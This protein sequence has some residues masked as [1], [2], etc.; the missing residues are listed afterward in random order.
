MLT[1]ILAAIA[2]GLSTSATAAPVI[3]DFTGSGRTCA[4]TESGLN[5]P[6]TC[7][8]DVSFTGFMRLDVDPAGPSGF[9]SES[10]PATK[11]DPDGWV[12]SFF[13]IRWAGG[14]FVT[15]P[16][17]HESRRE[18]WAY[19]GLIEH[20]DRNYDLMYVED[21]IRLGELR[22]A[23][24]DATGLYRTRRTVL[25]LATDINIRWVDVERF[26]FGITLSPPSSEPY[27]FGNRPM[28]G[29]EDFTTVNNEMQAGSG[30]G[31]I[32]LSSLVPRGAAAQVPEP[33]TWVLALLS[34]VAIAAGLRRRSSL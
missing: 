18:D 29:F 9:G 11:Y 14:T 28:I 24:D 33:Q 22:V 4:Y 5:P 3:Y 32:V 17:P 23:G 26:P 31:S 20:Y 12:D 8:E 19:V 2:L 21:V 30:F 7:N 6:I 15:T 13:N 34:A 1:R 10:G 25:S 16:I 27:P